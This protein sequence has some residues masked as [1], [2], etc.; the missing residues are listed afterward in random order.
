MSGTGQPVTEAK[1]AMRKTAAAA[2]A[3]LTPA[4]REEASRQM[5][6]ALYALP[7]YQTAETIFVYA[8]MPEEVQLYGLMEQAVLAGRTVCLPMITGKGTMEAVKL[9]SMDD[10]VPGRFGI[11][12]VDPKKQCI[13]PADRIDFMVVP[14]VAFDGEGR[15]LG[16]GAGYYDRF[17]GEKASHAFCCALAFDC[18]LMTEVP[19][20]PHD[21][22]VQY[23]ITE[24]QHFAVR[25]K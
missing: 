4:Y 9:P 1:K 21:V 8:S 16:L 15:R 19:V 5:L 10:L 2:R 13:I 17:M 12:T 23:I 18:Q 7:E 6:A 11:L 22:R 25:K 14:G 24:K 20:E 3:A